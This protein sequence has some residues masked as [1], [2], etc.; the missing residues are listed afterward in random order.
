MEVLPTIIEVFTA[1]LVARPPRILRVTVGT[2]T[3]QQVLPISIDAVPELAAILTR[4]LPEPNSS[5]S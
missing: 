2:S 3:G 4:N 1:E 5:S